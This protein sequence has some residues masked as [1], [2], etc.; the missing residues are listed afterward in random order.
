M[1]PGTALTLKFPAINNTNMD[2]MRNYNVRKTSA[3]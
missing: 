3:P 2:P 1:N